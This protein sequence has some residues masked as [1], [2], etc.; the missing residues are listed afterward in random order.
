MQW[1]PPQLASFLPIL[2]EATEEGILTSTSKWMRHDFFFSHFFLVGDLEVPRISAK[3]KRPRQPRIG[4]NIE[5]RH[6]Q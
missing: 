3:E 1:S 5:L 6:R 2:F 4:M